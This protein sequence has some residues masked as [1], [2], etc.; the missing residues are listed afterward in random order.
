MLASITLLNNYTREEHLKALYS[1]IKK[2]DHSITPIYSNNWINEIWLSNNR[3]PA[4]ALSSLIDSYYCLPDRPDMA[5]TYLWMSINNTY[6]SIATKH[7]L[8]ESQTNLLKE[9][10]A[11]DTFIKKINLIKNEPLTG[12]LT[13]LD[14][15]NEYVKL[16]PV[17]TLKFV[18]NHILKG[19][20][21][22]GAGIPTFL[23]S[24]SFKTFKKSFPNIYQSIFYTYG[25][26]Y[27]RISAPTVVNN[28]VD[29]GI[30]DLQ[31]SKSIPVSLAN[32]LKE[33]IVNKTTQMSNSVSN[34]SY[35]AIFNSD[36]E[37]INFIFRII[38]YSIRNNSV[39]GNVVQ[40][41]NSEYKNLDSLKASNYIY[42]LGHLFLSLGLYIN[43]DI[44]I[45]DLTINVDNLDK[46]RDILTA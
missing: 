9:S 40:R 18:S 36:E 33:L 14:L 13:L 3:V 8:T 42:Y 27:S 44:N 32:K 24:S 34:Q 21:S 30:T 7:K 2:I 5:F 22:E 6:N 25:S 46:L 16:I 1:D 23:I 10:E 45:Q 11:I 29:L 31:K 43:G 26:S 41:L 15:L 19:S 12:N 17:K 37:F 35:T 20:A 39:H 28:Y 4:V 38:L